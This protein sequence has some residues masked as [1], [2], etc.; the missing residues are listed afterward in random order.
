MDYQKIYDLDEKINLLYDY[1]YNTNTINC[2]IL[3]DIILGKI[4]INDIKI[5]LIDSSMIDEYENYEKNINDILN[6]K[7]KLINDTNLELNFKRYS[8]MYSSLLKIKFYTNE[9]Q[10]DS[11]I[12]E[13]NNDSLFS[14]ILSNLVLQK[15]TKH[16]LLPI[17]NID[18]YYD[19]IKNIIN[20]DILQQKIQ[21]LINTNKIHNI[22]CLQVREYYFQMKTLDVYLKDNS[23]T[24]NYKHLLFQIIHTLVIL[25]NEYEGFRHN[26]LKLNNI[27]LYLK[28]SSTDYIE[29][30]GFYNDK[31]YINNLEFEIKI[32]NF[33]KAIIP[34]FYEIL[35]NDK[36][37]HYF[38]I[39]TFLNDLWNFINNNNINIDN[40][41]KSF[42]ELYL[43]NNLINNYNNSILI[44][45]IDL[46]YDQFFDEFK[47]NNINDNSENQN[48]KKYITGI[49]KSLDFS[50]SVII[51]KRFINDKT[52]DFKSDESEEKSE[53]KLIISEK[54]L[55]FLTDSKINNYKINTF[56]ESD[57]ES[58]LGNQKNINQ[59]NINHNKKSH[60][61]IMYKIN[62]R[63]V[64]NY[65]KDNKI[66]R[67]LISDGNKILKGG[68]D[69]T[70]MP[71]Y[72]AEKNTPFTSNDQKKIQDIRNKENPIREPP[73]LLEQK[74]YDTAQKPAPKPQFPPTFIPL[75]DQDGT[76]M[77]HLLPYSNV[78]NQQPTQKVYNISL[79]NPL[80]SYTSINKIYEDI[81]PGDP[82]VFTA[83]T[84][85]ERSQLIDFF[86]NNILESHD[87]EEMTITGGKNSL[88]SYIKILDIN[89]YVLNKDPYKDLSAN[90]LLYRAA[91]PVR[92]EQ[93]SKTINI[94]KPSMGINIR[95]YMMTYGDLNCQKI[96]F[97]NGEA[98]NF[99]L[100]REIKY[101]DFIKNEIVKK[102]ISPNFICPILYKTDSKSKI[103]WNKLEMI[104]S[105]GIHKN[106][107]LELNDNQKKINSNHFI[108]KNSGLITNFLPNFFIL[109]S[110]SKDISNTQNKD[111][112]KEDITI[113]SGNVLI[114]L[115]EAPTS[116]I[117]QWSSVIYESFGSVKKMISSGYHTPDV[118]KSILFQLVY[119]FTVLQ[120]KSV[121]IENFSLDNNV[122]IKDIN[123]DPNS[124][125]SWIYKVNNIDYYIPNFGYILLIDSK[126]TDIQIESKLINENDTNQNK[127]FKI[128]GDIYNFNSDENM[129]KLKL[130]I[131]LQF[132]S[133]INPDNFRH[134]LKIKGGSIPDDSVLNLLT[135]MHKFNSN[136][137]KDYFIEF[138]KNFLHNRVGT[139]LTKTE[140]ENINLNFN[141]IFKNNEGK[142]MPYLKRFQE[143][144]W[145]I[146][147]GDNGPRKNI[148]RMINNNLEIVQVFP[149]TLKSY[150]DNEKI[151]PETKKS[152]KYDE[153]YIYETYDLNNLIK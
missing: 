34:K 19:K 128:Y 104:K 52:L 141:P 36:I 89:P 134:Q 37:N 131:L 113:N 97:R 33:D 27:Y 67:V 91:Y 46:I 122:Y 3:E 4:S 50:E 72:K 102:K 123:S 63:I 28:K 54:S 30:T 41:L 106:T 103:D 111:I 118:W 74:I 29:Y 130:K 107:T 140:K 42:F 59:D 45:P 81:L 86:R 136:N 143:Y 38:D 84:I 58:V 60:L 23:N 61:N 1:I 148:I 87:G 92:L 14:Y 7:F 44:K 90:F 65:N 142:L 137:I 112:D 80:G 21:D 48:S 100:W 151:F 139:L 39:Y 66:N 62:K 31:F 73:I 11:F 129:N 17:I 70:E 10:I 108:K 132:K 138:F 85:F 125:G 146:Y 71:P 77:N 47:G 57:K 22:C 2:F 5:S 35:N 135:N 49:E 152:M 121:Y 115:T 110:K 83:L 55:N 119:A 6:A 15:K 16:I 79:T 69:K 76:T 149:T 153:S 20:N 133:I 64:K 150:P 101:Y 24:I 13:I 99:D 51:G 12:S 53:T 124:I 75:Y 8:D 82:S 25:Q 145:V 116:S 109:N 9:K 93:K 18:I 147:L 117:I 40:E 127:K 26:N 56:I 144:E 94:G 105:Q 68:G 95:I 32:A 43:P 126:Y 78:V 120:E 98:D 114:L 88:L 96:K